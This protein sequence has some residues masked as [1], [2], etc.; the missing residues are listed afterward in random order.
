MEELDISMRMSVLSSLH[1]EA[2][3]AMKKQQCTAFLHKL[4]STLPTAAAPTDEHWK[5]KDIHLKKHAFHYCT[6]ILLSAKPFKF[7]F[8]FLSTAK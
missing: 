6:D 5:H 3:E 7:H 4:L 8:L 1:M 2:L